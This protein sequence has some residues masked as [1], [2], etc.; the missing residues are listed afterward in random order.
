[1][2]TPRCF[3]GD[4]RVTDDNLTVIRRLRRLVL[5]NISVY[6][7]YPIRPIWNAMKEGPSVSMHRRWRRNRR[8]RRDRRGGHGG[9]LS[10]S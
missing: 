7:N 9:T 1:M 8:W 5:R 10:K 6:S 4:I 3:I 2:A